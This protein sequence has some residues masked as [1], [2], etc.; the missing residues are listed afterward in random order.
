MDVLWHSDRDLQSY[1]EGGDLKQRRT[2]FLPCPSSFCLWSWRV[3]RLDGGRCATAACYYHPRIKILSSYIYHKHFSSP[4]CCPSHSVA[5]VI[6]ATEQKG[7]CL[8]PPHTDSGAAQFLFPL[9]IPPNL[10]YGSVGLKV[11]L[12]QLANDL[13]WAVGKY[14]SQLVL[15]LKSLRDGAEGSAKSINLSENGDMIYAGWVAHSARAEGL[16]TGTKRQIHAT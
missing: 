12:F 1:Q 14:L 15:V 2:R 10:S 7:D 6:G 16:G 11:H 13:F 8:S 3:W 9:S 5:F 4:S